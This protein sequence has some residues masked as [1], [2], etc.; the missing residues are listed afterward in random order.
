MSVKTET[1]RK[2]EG[3]IH[4][5]LTADSSPHRAA[6]GVAIGLFVAMTPTLGMQMILAGGLAMAFR[7]N[8][9][10]SLT[11]VWITN[12]LTAIPIFLF[13]YTVGCWLLRKDCR[14]STFYQFIGNMLNLKDS[15]IEKTQT[16]RSLA[17][18]LFLPLWVGSLMVAVV[19]ASLS[20]FL[21]R[22][23]VTQYQLGQ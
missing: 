5:I 10:L 18:G 16:A 11:F 9:T 4:R 21:V 20:Y 13:N 6:L 15:G 3:L 17:E 7:A 14:S 1:K 12:A 2:K 19:V 22:T 23:A 8:K